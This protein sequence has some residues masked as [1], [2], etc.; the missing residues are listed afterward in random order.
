MIDYRERIKDEECY[1]LGSI[2]LVLSP[3]ELVSLICLPP[4]EGVRVPVIRD[5][6]PFSLEGRTDMF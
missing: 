1:H 6:Y 5:H 2:Y 3:L 4:A